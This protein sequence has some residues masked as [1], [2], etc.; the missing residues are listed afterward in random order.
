MNNNYIGYISSRAINGGMIPHRVQNIIV[1]N[2]ARENSLQYNLSATEFNLGTSHSMLK[3]ILSKKMKG[4]LFYSVLMLPT[5]KEDIEQ[6]FHLIIQN[7][8]ELH[9]CAE[10]IFVNSKNLKQFQQ[11]LKYSVATKINH[12]DYFH[13]KSDKL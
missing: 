8:L 11:T 4:I 12:Q 13:Y 10:S 6:I 1:R 9:F 7:D 5:K 3:N 2:Y